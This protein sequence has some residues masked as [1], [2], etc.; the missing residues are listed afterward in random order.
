MQD[1]V[2]KIMRRCMCD[3]LAQD[4]SLT[5]RKGKRPFIGLYLLQVLTGAIFIYLSCVACIRTFAFQHA[6]IFSCQLTMHRLE[7]LNAFPV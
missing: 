4:F 5:G 2:R 3:T 1:S 6:M 7:A